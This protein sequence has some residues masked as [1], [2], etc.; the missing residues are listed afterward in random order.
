MNIN[1]NVNKKRINSVNVKKINNN[2]KNK[3]KKKF[4]KVSTTYSLLFSFFLNKKRRSVPVIFF[5]ILNYILFRKSRIGK[6]KYNFNGPKF[7]TF[8]SLFLFLA[9]SRCF[10]K[11]E[12]VEFSVEKA[13][14]FLQN[15]LHV[16]LLF[17]TFL[18]NILQKSTVLDFARTGNGELF[19]FLDRKSSLVSHYKKK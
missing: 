5:K 19:D 13:F 14:S 2:L 10:L 15:I 16:F 17:Y 11:S 6:K 1:K 12:R 3:T 8:L 9:S 18:P 4:L 7:F